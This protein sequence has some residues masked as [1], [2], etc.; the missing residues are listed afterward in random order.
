MCL[1]IY[2]KGM[3]MNK[4]T[5]RITIGIVFLVFL[6]VSFVPSFYQSTSGDG[7][8]NARTV[9]LRSPIEGVLHLSRPTKCG[10]LFAKDEV[11]GKVVNDRIN[12]SFLHE[13]MTEK[14]TLES[15][16]AIMDDRQAEFSK[17]EQR[18]NENLQ[19]YQKYSAKQ[20]EDQIHQNDEKLTQ[21]Q[22]EYDRAK[23]EYD[24]NRQLLDRQALKQREFDNSEANYFK[25]TARIRELTNRQVELKNSLEAVNS[26]VFLGDGH[27]DVPYSSQRRDQL[28]IETSLAK[29]A[30]TEAKDRIVGIDQQIAAERERLDKMETFTLSSPFNSVVWRLT[31]TEGS[32]VVIDTPLIVLLDCSSVFLDITLSESQFSDIA[33]GDTIRYRL[34][35]E[36]KYHKGKVFA[37]RGSGSDV[38]DHNLAASLTKDPKREFH[39]WASITPED[40][41]LKPENFYQVGHRVEVKIPRHWNV[42]QEIIRFFNVF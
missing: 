24:A 8:I 4:R 9:T 21:E 16:I 12:R 14:R 23:K 35:G 28:V 19:K 3:A 10:V 20:L 18:L 2:R 33:G 26:G 34:I 5:L 6:I 39:V 11:I 41:G 30:K 40:L 29:A 13:L 31:E 37:L 27:N 1:S 38:S 36:S 7:L 15:R 22:A 25:S 17:L 42:W 32:T